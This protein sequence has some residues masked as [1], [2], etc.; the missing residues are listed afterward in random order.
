M[1]I[2]SQKYVI[3]IG[4]VNHILGFFFTADVRT[5]T[6]MSMTFNRLVLLCDFAAFL[7]LF[8]RFLELCDILRIIRCI[9]VDKL[10]S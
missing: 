3:D 6:V 4:T 9:Y 7:S 2:F 1:R 5:P 8:I 10:D